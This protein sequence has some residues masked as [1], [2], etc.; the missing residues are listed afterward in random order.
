M[1]FCGAPEQN[2]FSCPAG[3]GLRSITEQIP[4]LLNLGVNAFYL[5]PLFE[6][7]AHGY[8]TLDYYYVDRRLGNNGD[9]CFLVNRF[10]EAGIV[11]VLDAVLNHVGRHFFAFKD[12]Q[13]R[14]SASAYRDWFANVDFGSRSPA[15]DTF[16]Y[17][18]WNGC[19]DLVKLNAHNRLVRDYLLNAVE[20]WI[21][22]FDIDGLRLDAA[23]LL[24]PDFLDELSARS[25]KVKDNFWLMGEVVAGDYTRWTG[26]GSS[27]VAHGTRLDS[28][29]NYELYKSLWSSFNDKN[30]FELSW[31]LNRQSGA[32]GMYRDIPLYTFA[33][34][35]DVNRIASVLKNKAHL[36]PLYGLLF[37]LPGI[38]SIYYGSEYGIPGERLP[39]SDR[40]LRP[41]WDSPAM[42]QAAESAGIAA[43]TGSLERAIAAFIRLRK[44]SAALR[45]GSF[46]ELFKSHEQYAFIREFGGERTVVVV[47]AAEEQKTI[48]ISPEAL[49]SAG[50]EKWRDLLSGEEFTASGTGLDI[51]VHPSWLRV[52]AKMQ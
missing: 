23:D 22:E 11:V 29:T 28:V 47:N 24:L 13:E 2:D 40:P 19:Y 33:D 16:T 18:G 10:H 4:H 26:G 17:E 31:T 36:F 5:G 35:H 25:K 3:T 41:A 8:D 52:L 1:G 51:P 12:L 6:S 50:H 44:N 27:G 21:R 9:L 14:G 30:F 32:D 34:N 39:Y 43:G 49:G 37:T 42:R 20:Y 15:G 46:R 38:P 45:E 7:T 48:P